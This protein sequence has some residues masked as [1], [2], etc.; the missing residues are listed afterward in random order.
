ME[1]LFS[2]K[3]VKGKNNKLHAYNELCI[4]GYGCI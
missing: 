3:G 2:T 1:V 4:E